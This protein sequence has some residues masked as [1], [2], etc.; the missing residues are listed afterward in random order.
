MENKVDQVCK[1]KT[2]FPDSFKI[3]AELCEIK[4]ECFRVRARFRSV[5][6]RY[7]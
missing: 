6:I 5:E 2:K 7:Y 3:E 1:L 4:I